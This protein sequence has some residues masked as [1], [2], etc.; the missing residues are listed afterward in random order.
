M[1][2]HFAVEKPALAHLKLPGTE[3]K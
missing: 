2:D 1:E 3:L